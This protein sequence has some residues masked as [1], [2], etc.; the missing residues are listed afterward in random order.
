MNISRN[1]ICND[2]VYLNQ[3]GTHILASNFV[4][5]IKTIDSIFNFN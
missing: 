1:Y 5:L 3:K 2:D 4:T